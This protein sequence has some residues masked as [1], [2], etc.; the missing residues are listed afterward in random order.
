VAASNVAQEVARKTRSRMRRYGR[1]GRG[2][3]RSRSD[4]LYRSIQHMGKVSLVHFLF[5]LLFVS[6]T[7]IVG[8]P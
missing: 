2:L 5:L 3:N 1:V 7:S 8:G 4:I 6:I